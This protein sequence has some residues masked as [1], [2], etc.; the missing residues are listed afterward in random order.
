MAGNI[1]GITIEFRGDTTS[2]DKALRKVQT[3]T[4][5]IDRELKQVNNALKFN[6]TSV[7]LWRQKQDLLRQKIEQTKE[8]LKD[9]KNAQAQMDAQGVDKQSEA[10]RT[11]Q[12]EIIATESKLK[13]YEAQLR[14]IGQVNL[15]AASEQFK[16]LGNKLTTA[17]RAMREFSMAGAAVV[18]V[19]G[20]MAYKAA[21]AADDL[22]TMSKVYGISTQDLQKYKLAAEQVDVSVTAIAKS[23]TKLKKSMY[24]A[25]DDSGSAAEAFKTLGVEIKNADGTLRDGDAVWQDTIAALGKME[26]ETERDAIAMQ[27]MGK[28]ASELNPL[29]EDGGETYKRTAELFEKYN[30]GLIDQD[31]L[32][33]AE[34]F[35]DGLDDIKSMGSLAFSMLGAELDEYLLPVMQKVVAVIGKIVSWLS[36]LNPKV[37]AIIGA[38][39]GVVAVL[40]PALLIAGKIAFA[41]SSILGLMSTLGISLAALAGP[42]GIVIA[43][44]A[45]LI[46]IGV[47][48]YKHWDE[49]KAKAAELK[50]NLVA[51]FNSLKAAITQIFENI[52]NVL[53]T[54]WN[55]IKTVITAAAQ[56]IYSLTIG[57]FQLILTTARSIFEALRSAASSIWAG[58]KNAMVSPIETAKALITSII[59]KIKSLFPVNIG[60]AFNIKLPHVSVGS[61]E[62]K[63]GD[64][65]V[66]IPTFSVDWYA[67]GGIFDQASLIGVGEAGPE[68]VVPLDKFWEEIRATN[69]RTD[70]ILA[71]QNKILVA[72]YE[73]LRKEKNFK[74]DNVW[75]GRYVN[76]LVKQ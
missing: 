30:L 21:S 3:S 57:R 71:Q 67:K 69:E 2:L 62:V 75:A 61:K 48:L 11:V 29:I 13:S 32:D 10:Y 41:I 20:T 26:N 18:G 50:T 54:I 46:A 14:K 19:L 5:D 40:G 6:P 70:S 4:K 52:R 73:E 22:N 15:R 60:K 49:I 25:K 28:S 34:Q 63:A 1:K 55:G 12:R 31:T 76:S 65:T 68:A 58:I 7:D 42:V 51:T 43:V 72:M 37:L 44:I 9:L 35:K 39:A 27:L 66:K 17:G 38:V 56:I 8:N 59:N 74:V 64:K 47:L 36:N 45:A 24:S 16:E 53:T 33:K 23:H